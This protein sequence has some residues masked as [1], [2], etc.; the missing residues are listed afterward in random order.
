MIGIKKMVYG[1]GKQDSEKNFG[2]S[3]KSGEGKQETIECFLVTIKMNDYDDKMETLVY[4]GRISKQDD[5]MEKSIERLNEYYEKEERERREAIQMI[6]DIQKQ[7]ANE[8]FKMGDKVIIEIT[9][10]IGQI[11]EVRPRSL[12]NKI[13]NELKAKGNEGKAS[14]VLPPYKVRVSNLLV[15]DVSW[16]WMYE[17]ELESEEEYRKKEAAET[18]HR[19]REYEKCCNGEHTF[20]CNMCDK[21]LADFENDKSCDEEHIIEEVMEEEPILGKVDDI[22]GCPERDVQTRYEE[23]EKSEV[24][25]P[26]WCA[27]CAIGRRVSNGWQCV[28][29][30]RF[31]GD[32]TSSCPPGGEHLKHEPRVSVRLRDLKHRAPS[33]GVHFYGSGHGTP[34]SNCAEIISKRKV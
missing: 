33:F 19:R 15:S 2:K 20:M 24:F 1:I 8:K 32:S 4:V 30:G 11:L 25:L 12:Y 17:F 34:L 5:F 16:I 23:I 10:G 14:E 28:K 22:K 9:G 31:F 6:H 21:T 27:S 7:L 18:E 29:C 3:T 13:D 26:L